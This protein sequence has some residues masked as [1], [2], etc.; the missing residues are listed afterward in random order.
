[1][2]LP[3]LSLVIWGWAVAGTPVPG[4]PNKVMPAPE[5]DLGSAQAAFGPDRNQTNSDVLAIIR[6]GTSDDQAPR[7]LEL[8]GEENNDREFAASS[9]GKAYK[10]FI[11][12]LRQELG[13]RNRFS[14]N[15][16]LLPPQQNPPTS[17]FD[18]VITTQSR[19]VRFR[20]R[21]DNL[22]IDGYQEATTPTPGQWYEFSNRRE[23]H[24]ISGSRF[25]GFSGSYTSL[26]SVAGRERNR[27]GV[28]QSALVTSVNNLATSNDR[29]VRA[30]ALIVVT[31]MFSEA[32]R[33]TSI[34]EHIWT[35]YNGDAPLPE[36]LIALENGWGAI[37][38][39]LLHADVSPAG[40]FRLTSDNNDMG[41]GDVPTAIAHV[42]LLL[43]RCVV[44][45]QVV[46][47][48]HDIS[49]RDEA[50]STQPAAAKHLMGRPLVE[51]FAVKVKNI[52]GETPGDLYGRISVTDALKSQVLYSV[53]RNEHQSIGPND[54]VPLT[55]PSRSIS[56]ADD[57]K[58]DFDLMDQDFD[59]SPDDQVSRGRVTFHVYDPFN[60]FDKVIE[61]TIWGK[62]GHVAMNYVIMSNAAE[63]MVE[64]ILI[65]GDDEHPADVYGT[66]NAKT[67]HGQRKMFGRSAGGRVRTNPGEKVWLTRPAIAVPLDGKL[68]LDIDLKDHDRLPDISPDDQIALGTVEWVPQPGHSDKKR[69]K[70]A[71]GEIEVRV[72]WT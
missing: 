49:G 5:M 45:E 67:P 57:F 3:A 9:G 22:Y 69:V 6:S 7:S 8:R 52:D 63:A 13:D 38:G 30:R 32:L 62:Y 65:N 60:E 12:R 36:S 42:G 20:L 19:R 1:M 23:A 70:A 47:H 55:G 35:N 68:V 4:E 37:S 43:A 26:Q 46:W 24:L 66:I 27:V 39:A 54:D 53:P 72:T 41:I 64:V 18:L 10:D 40:P 44:A 48:G 34:S 51:I 71:H 61:N 59:P 14:H 16:P 17:W 33:F 21:R 2:R 58:V 15:L 11:R 28:G 25:L 56:A 50:G 31:Q 29:A